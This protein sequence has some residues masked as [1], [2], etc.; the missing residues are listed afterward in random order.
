MCFVDLVHVQGLESQWRELNALLEDHQRLGKA[1]SEQLLAYEKLRDQVLAWLT[2]TE[3]RVAR[4]EPVALDM[5]TIKR[6]VDELKVSCDQILSF[7]L[8]R[9]LFLLLKDKLKV[10]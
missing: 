2:Q 3:T 1:R 8:T 10:A 7:V 4:L 9:I 5:D 6:Q